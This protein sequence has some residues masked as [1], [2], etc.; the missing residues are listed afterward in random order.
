VGG[1][2]HTTHHL[3]Y[4]GFTDRQVALSFLGLSFLSVIFLIVIDQVIGDSWDYWHFYLFLG[5]FLILF[6]FLYG[7]TRVNK[8]KEN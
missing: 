4:L 3:S 7:I 1:K 8:K 5:Y 6:G 2:D